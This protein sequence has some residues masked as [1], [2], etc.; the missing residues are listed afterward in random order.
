MDGMSSN[1]VV[2]VTGGA[3]RIGAEICTRFHSEGWSVIVHYNASK[4]E[5]TALCD[6]M[7]RVRPGSATM[8]YGNLMSDS[9]EIARHAKL[10]FGRIDALVNNASIAPTDTSMAGDPLDWLKLFQCNV[11]SPFKIATQL[12]EALS[13]SGGAIVNILDVRATT[14]NPAPDWAMYTA[15]KAAFHSLTLSL[16]KS[17]APSVRVNGVSPGITLPFPWE[18]EDEDWQAMSHRS[19][20]G[21]VASPSDIADAVFFM[22]ESK[23]IVGQVITVDGG[24]ALR[25]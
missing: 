14:L 4:K 17:L 24:E 12:Q 5:A 19:L 9:F 23:H 11:F 16:A 7:N 1:K 13:E 18:K 2:L 8:I 15:T 20:M 6:Q 3:K 21:R 10:K 25:W 22:A